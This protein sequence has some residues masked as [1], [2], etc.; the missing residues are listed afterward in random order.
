MISPE[1]TIFVAGAG[2][3]VGRSVVM[4]LRR[5]GFDRLLT[6]G[7]HSV[8]LTSGQQTRQFFDSESPDIVVLAAATAGGIGLNITHPADLIH[9]NL[10]IAANVIHAAFEAHVEKLVFVGSA[11]VYP[12]E[13]PQP[14]REEQL[15]AGPLEP[16][17]E[18]YAL[19]KI[20]GIKLCE[21]YARQHGRNFFSLTPPNLYGPNDR[22][23]SGSAH[24]IPS[25]IA[26]FHQARI[27]GDDSVSVWG[28]GRPR[29]EFMHVDDLATAIV[30]ALET[31]DADDVYGQG[32]SHLNVGTGTDMTIGETAALVRDIVGFEGEIEFDVSKPD[33]VERKLLDVTRI[34]NL[35]WGHRIELRE[36]IRRTYDWY[37]AN[38]D[39]AHSASL[40]VS[41]PGRPVR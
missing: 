11:C 2:G 29:R 20:A 13:T 22:F 6:P 14:M 3:M 27:A 7:S 15:L 40:E 8:D 24:V 31:I 37:L 38:S 5:R 12:K 21:S 23:G 35:G 28:S 17:V 41:A 1:K 26:R 4:E 16:T 18:Y 33:G 10:L 30:F 9:R 39:V 36:G 25:L 19:A 34:R 32:I